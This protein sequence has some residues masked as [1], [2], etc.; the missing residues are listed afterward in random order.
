MGTSPAA[1]A[2]TEKELAYLYASN[3]NVSNFV[4]VRLSGDRNYHLWKTQMLC[5]LEAHGMRG[6]VDDNGPTDSRR[7][8]G[9]EYE[10]LLKGWIFGSLSEDV[11]RIVVDHHSAES[12]WEKL[13]R[14]F[15]S[16]NTSDQQGVT[17]RSE[18]LDNSYLPKNITAN[19]DCWPELP[20]LTIYT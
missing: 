19:N 20:E 9:K 10:I 6:L 2:K 15:G 18:A 16:Y 12:V 13:E 17:T 1:S 7:N 14:C 11:L 4:S 5:L 3:T 8:T